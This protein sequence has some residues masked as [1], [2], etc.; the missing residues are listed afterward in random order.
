MWSGTIS[1][2][3]VA[4]PVDLFP[5]QRSV[6]LS[7][8]MLA[9]DGMP[10]Q[11]RYR[12]PKHDRDLDRDE[13]ARGYELEDGTFVVLDDEDLEAIAPRKSRDIDLRRFVDAD[14]I[15]PFAFQR[16]YVLTP[17]GDSTKPYRLLAEV[18]ERERRVGI[19][20]FVMRGKE[21]LVAILAH[22]G[23]LWAETLR[24]FGELRDA[25]EIG[26]PEAPE[27]AKSSIDVF[28][29]AIKSL[30]TAEPELTKLRDERAAALR[31]LVERKWRAGEDIV[32]VPEAESEQ[33]PAVDLLSADDALDGTDP[34]EV[35]RQR[36]EGERPAAAKRRK[37]AP[38]LRELSKQALYER[39]QQLDV[40]G[41]SSM[42]KAELVAAL[43]RRDRRQA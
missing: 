40:P 15:E 30:R 4:V 36:L 39:A 34:F 29:R 13:L 19:A 1:F 28:T 7:L 43:G 16:A 31:E 5:A 10:L 2:G 3:L 37:S 18:M 24:A 38:S 11:R 21:Y 32:D 26:L 22:D 33:P 27:L 14:A 20:T 12:C 23:I 9:P 41:R 6:G 8:R 25:E 17:S 42:S 35:I